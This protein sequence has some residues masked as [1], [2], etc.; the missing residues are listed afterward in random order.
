V[1][2]CAVAPDGSYIVSGGDY[3]PADLSNG[4]ILDEFPPPDDRTIVE[5]LGI[6]DSMLRIWDPTTGETIAT[7]TGHTGAVNACAI[8]PDG[9]YIVSAA[10]SGDDAFGA[11]RDDS[12][13]L[14]TPPNH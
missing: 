5:D 14:W 3:P 10:G 12:L 1:S 4:L 2:A 7:L 13:R 11:P 6:P 8:S 9:S